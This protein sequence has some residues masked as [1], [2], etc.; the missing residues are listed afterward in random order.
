MP[1]PAVQTVRL[2]SVSVASKDCLAAITSEVN[3]HWRLP[4]S[5]LF[6]IVAMIDIH[7]EYQITAQAQKPVTWGR[8][9]EVVD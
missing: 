8:A 3:K 5:A 2:G 9:V 1:F 6:L 7:R 4:E